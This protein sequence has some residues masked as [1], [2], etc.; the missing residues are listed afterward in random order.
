MAILSALR[1][2]QADML[3]GAGGGL[4]SLHQD[5]PRRRS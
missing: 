1:R 2:G 3:G 4:F 5:F